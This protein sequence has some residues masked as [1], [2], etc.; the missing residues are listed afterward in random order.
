MR[1]I[2]LLLLALAV[3]AAAQEAA[4]E[5]EE[6]APYFRP[7][8]QLMRDWQRKNKQAPHQVTVR[9]DAE[10]EIQVREASP[11][12]IPL[13]EIQPAAGGSTPILPPRE[14]GSIR[15]IEPPAPPCESWTSKPNPLKP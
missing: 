1:A 13:L 2:C 3:P 7:L 10:P 12:S 5:P 4:P 11:C 6:E 9:P 15:V 8:D 14:K